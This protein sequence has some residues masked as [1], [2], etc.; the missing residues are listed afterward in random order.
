VIRVYSLESETILQA[1]EQGLKKGEGMKKNK[2]ARER[3]WK[4]EGP[5]AVMP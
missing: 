2:T 5:S 3:E 1:E 4:R